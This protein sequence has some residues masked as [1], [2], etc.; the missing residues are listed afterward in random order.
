MPAFELQVLLPV[1]NEDASIEATVRSMPSF[2]RVVKIF[3]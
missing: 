1:H 3:T 2:P